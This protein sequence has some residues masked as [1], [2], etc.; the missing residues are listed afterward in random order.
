[1]SFVSS[2][3]PRY[4]S[5]VCQF[6]CVLLMVIIVGS[7]SLVVKITASVFSTFIVRHP[8]SIVLYDFICV[9]LKDSCEYFR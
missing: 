1:M 7:I 6:I 8:G 5:F 2:V 3:V 4:F 9:A